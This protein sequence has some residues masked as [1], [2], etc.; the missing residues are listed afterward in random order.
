MKHFLS[1]LL[2]MLVA[3]VPATVANYSCFGAVSGVSISNGGVVTVS[4]FGGIQ[5]GYICQ[6]GA[7]APNGISSDTCKAIYARLL[8]AEVTGQQLRV[9]FND[10]L[11][12]T[13]Q[14]TW[15]WLTGLYF[16]PGTL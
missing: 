1:L 15:G 7:S 14:P 10:T 12:C 5:Y 8:V 9:Y 4:G 6:I 11:S 2:V 16:G 13:T 3:N